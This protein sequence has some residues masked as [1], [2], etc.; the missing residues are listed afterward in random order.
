[1]GKPVADNEF[2]CV[3]EFVFVFENSTVSMKLASQSTYR[4]VLHVFNVF[5]LV[6]TPVRDS[7]I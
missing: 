6:L 3:F 4:G 7:N 5:C 2:E 1:L